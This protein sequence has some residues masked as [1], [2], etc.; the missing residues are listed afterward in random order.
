[1]YKKLEIFIDI[2]DIIDEQRKQLLGLFDYLKDIFEK[3]KDKL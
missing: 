2:E 1:M 3:I